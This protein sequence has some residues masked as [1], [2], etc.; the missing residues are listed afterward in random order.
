MNT[1][2]VTEEIKREIKK[3]SRNKWQWKHDNS[4]PM[5]CSKNSSKMEVFSNTIL[6]QE[7]GKILNRQ[8]NL[9]QLEKE[10]QRKTQN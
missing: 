5:G 2:Q 1:Q 6:P 9:K 3:I 7:T 8:P 10:E 4:K